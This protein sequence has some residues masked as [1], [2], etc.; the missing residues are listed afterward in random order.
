MYYCIEQPVLE[1][2][3]VENNHAF[4]IIIQ[5]YIL[6]HKVIPTDMAC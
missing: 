4:I 5:K 3:K 2:G 1:T 6:S